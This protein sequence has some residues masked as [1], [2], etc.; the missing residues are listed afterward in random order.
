MSRVTVV[1]AFRAATQ[2]LAMFSAAVFSACSARPRPTAVG[3]TE[4]SARPPADRP[5]AESRLSSRS[6]SSVTAAA[7][8]GST[9]SSPRKSRLT[10]SPSPTRRRATSSAC[11]AV[12]P[13]TYRATRERAPGAVVMR[14]RSTVVDLPGK[15]HRFCPDRLLALSPRRG[16]ESGTR[17]PGGSAQVIPPAQGDLHGA[18]G[19]RRNDDLLAGR[20]APGEQRG[21]RGNG[22]LDQ[23]QRDRPKLVVPGR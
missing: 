19:V 21:I 5:S 10:S 16:G 12:S 23:R 13:A 14:R 17:L 2:I 18:A 9:V 6:Y 15:R 1:P 20:D 4:T 8:S 7:C 3:L 22:P 11:S